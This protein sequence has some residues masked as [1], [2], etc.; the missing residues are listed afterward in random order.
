MS[1]AFVNTVREVSPDRTS[2][3][4]ETSRDPAWK[5]GRE[6]VPD[7]PAETFPD[8]VHHPTVDTLNANREGCCDRG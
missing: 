5:P 8:L 6:G 2:L 3:S 4:F 1:V 7:R